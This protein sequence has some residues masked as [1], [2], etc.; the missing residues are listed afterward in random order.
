MRRILSLG[1][2]VLLFLS[3]AVVAA[4]A[5]ASKP[6]SSYDAWF[7]STTKGCAAIYKCSCSPVSNYLS[8]SARAQYLDNGAYKWT[9]TVS[10]SGNNVKQRA[11]VIT[12]P[13]KQKVYY[14]DAD[15]KAKC[16]T[17][18]LKSYSDTANRR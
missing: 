11:F 5:T 14:V 6:Y 10:S 2:V 1:L 18:S 15:F 12:S 7:E 17:G 4:S 9:S 16:G 8:A 13:A 3:I